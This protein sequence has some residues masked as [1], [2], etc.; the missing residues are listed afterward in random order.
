MLPL[1]SRALSSA[2]DSLSGRPSCA[3]GAAA[4]V[5]VA[6]GRVR[7]RWSWGGWPSRPG[8]DD[9]GTVCG[10]LGW[11]CPAGGG[12]GTAGTCGGAAL[13]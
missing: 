5:A 6:V 9:E 2:R 4:I 12:A 11:P 10:R 13:A 7:R 8:A 1:A 3:A